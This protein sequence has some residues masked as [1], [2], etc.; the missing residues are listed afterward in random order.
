MSSGYLTTLA[1]IYPNGTDL[2]NIFIPFGGGTF[3]GAITTNAGI[4]GPSTSIPYSAGMIGYTAK[5][6][7]TSSISIP[8]SSTYT[9][10]IVNGFT[11]P[12][13]V[14]LVRCVCANTYTSSASSRVLSFMNLGISSSNSGYDSTINK[15]FMMTATG[16]A[17]IPTNASGSISGLTTNIFNNTSSTNYNLLQ[18]IN[19]NT[20]FS[21]NQIT[22]TQS[23][24]YVTYTKIA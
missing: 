15:G 19:H 10:L 17:T 16:S 2:S 5:V 12:I 22:S 8:S 7:A 18:L 3:T 14:F 21:S 13:G 11:M 9:S 6:D 24:C 23:G 1:G 20:T 4:I